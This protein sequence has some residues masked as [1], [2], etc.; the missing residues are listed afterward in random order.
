M[1]FFS[2]FEVDAKRVG[3][4]LIEMALLSDVKKESEWLFRISINRNSIWREY[5]RKSIY[6]LVSAK[7]RSCSGFDEKCKHA[8]TWR[9]TYRTWSFVNIQCNKSYLDRSKIICYN[10]IVLYL[11]LLLPMLLVIERSRAREVD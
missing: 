7:L 5:S 11:L 6:L 8:E 3:A 1:Y 10:E 2:S 9:H 4:I